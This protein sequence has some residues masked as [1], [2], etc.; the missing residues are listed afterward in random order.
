MNTDLYKALQDAWVKATG[1][2]VGDKVRTL[3]KWEKG[4]LGFVYSPLTS[5][6]DLGE[7][8]IKSITNHAVRIGPDGMVRPFFV[9]EIIKPVEVQLTNGFA[10]I[11]A[12]DGV[13]ITSR[14]YG[15]LHYS[16]KISFDVI[17]ELADKLPKPVNTF[18]GKKMKPSEVPVG[19]YYQYDTGFCVYLRTESGSNCINGRPRTAD[20]DLD[21]LIRIH[22]KVTIVEKP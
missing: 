17:R 13:I 18:L 12:E 4:E 14:G 7:D 20:T 19:Q 21:E 16:P 22:K 3:R 2:K 8:I 9:L 6:I 10:A 15:Y 5:H 11:I 1:V